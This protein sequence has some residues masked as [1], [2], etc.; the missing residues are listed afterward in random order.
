MASDERHLTDH[1]YLDIAKKT[2]RH[3]DVI[4]LFKS[5]EKGIADNVSEEIIPMDARQEIRSKVVT[6]QAGALIREVSVQ[7]I[8]I[9][10][11]C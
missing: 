8:F 7:F 10:C 5:I 9:F 2:L 6:S 11:K 1:C 4:M 3:P